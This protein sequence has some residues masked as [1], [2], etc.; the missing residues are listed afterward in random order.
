MLVGGASWNRGASPRGV[1]SGFG[2]PE[3]EVERRLI[4]D[5]EDRSEAKKMWRAAVDVGAVG[6]EMGLSV[7]IGYIGGWWLDEKLGTAPYLSL[8]GLLAGVGAAGNALW[9]TAR[10]LKKEEDRTS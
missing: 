8:L 4:G 7:A 5:Q 1:F 9:R 6:V 2:I 3:P 10:R